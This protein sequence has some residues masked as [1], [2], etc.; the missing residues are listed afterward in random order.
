MAKTA[1]SIMTIVEPTGVE[2]IIEISIPPRAQTTEIIAEVITTPLKLLISRIADSAGK[3]IRA[4]ISN[5]PTRFIP[6]TM[7]TDVIM[8]IT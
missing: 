7:I 5:E 4:E 1:I 2:K 6:R 3:T 8:A